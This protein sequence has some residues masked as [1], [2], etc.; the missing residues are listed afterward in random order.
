MKLG[1]RSGNTSRTWLLILLAS[2]A[3]GMAEI[4][5]VALYSSVTPI[6]GMVVARE[7]TA[8]LFPALAAG[9]SG[10]WLGILIHMVLAVALGYAFAVVIWMPFFRG[11]GVLA[12]L[13][14]SALTLA[15]VWAVNFFVVLPTLNPVFITLVPYSVAFAS[16]MLFALSMALTLSGAEITSLVGRKKGTARI[17]G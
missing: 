10:A 5:W 11:R 1:H 12:T 7:V 3:G 16:K 15:A 17:A 14:V 9:A 6:E 4:F 8:S 2:L 13:T